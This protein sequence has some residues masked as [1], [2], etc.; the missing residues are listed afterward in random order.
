[1]S[2]TDGEKAAAASTW[3]EKDLKGRF[4][5]ETTSDEIANVFADRIKDKVVVI[6]GIGPGGIGADAARAIFKK[7]PKLLVLASRTHSNIQAVIQELEPLG[8]TDS[9][10]A[11]QLDLASQKMVRKAAAEL[12]DMTPVVD[13]LI[14]NAAVMA[15]PTFQT[16]EDGHELQFGVNHL[17]HFTFTNLIMPA[18]LKSNGGASVVNVSS[19]GSRAGGVRFEDPNFGMGKEYEKFLAYGQS[20]SANL[21]FSVALARKYGKV[22]LRSFGVDPGGC[23][24]TRLARE[25]SLQ[26]MIDRGWLMPNGSPN[27]DWVPPKSVQQGSAS[28][29]L[30]AFDPSLADSNGAVLAACNVDSSFPPHAVDPTFAERLWTLSENLVGEK[31]D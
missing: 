22:G 7:S 24:G 5:W 9:I 21:L 11:L 18:L 23:G 30:G 29:L 26:E 20:K 6:T 12:L 17:G 19:A 3:R 8:Q 13:A 1:M 25:I 2:L 10:R 27:P 16:T 31:F 15:T 4:N 28:Y 14:N